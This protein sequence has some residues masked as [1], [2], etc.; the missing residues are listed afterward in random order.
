MTSLRGIADGVGDE[1]DEKEKK[2]KGKKGTLAAG[3]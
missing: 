3:A 1:V 2:E